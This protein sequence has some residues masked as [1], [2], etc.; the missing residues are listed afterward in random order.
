MQFVLQ[1]A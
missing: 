1:D